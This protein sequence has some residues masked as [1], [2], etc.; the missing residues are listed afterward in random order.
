MFKLIFV[1]IAAGSPALAQ[2]DLTAQLDTM[3]KVSEISGLLGS[4]KICGLTYDQ[5]AIEKWIDDNA[6]ADQM[7]FAGQVNLQTQGAAYILKDQT[8]SARTAHCAAIRKTAKHFGF[9][10]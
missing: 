3:R 8:P 2:T 1:M 5:S 6:P 4:E 7:D 9:I 10:N